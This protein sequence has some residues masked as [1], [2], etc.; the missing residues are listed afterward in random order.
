LGTRRSA[1]VVGGKVC[2]GGSPSGS[3]AIVA[4]ALQKLVPVKSSCYSAENLDLWR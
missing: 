3:C 2:V 1:A 4:G